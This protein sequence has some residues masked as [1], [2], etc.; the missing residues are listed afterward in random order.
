MPDTLHLLLPDLA[1]TERLAARAAALARPGD[2]LLLE[3][4]LGAGKSA[5]CRAFLRAAAGDPELEVP[6]PSFTLVQG[7]A[8]P[9]GPAFHYDLYRLSG[10]E[11]LE[12]LGW[13]ESRDGIVLVEWPD[14]LGWLA[15]EDAL[16]LSLQ[17]DAGGEARHAVLRGWDSRLPALAG[18]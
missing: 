9:Q 4:P 7:Y 17:P 5:F 13:E 10:P 15:P 3:G 12:E 14:R 2:A 18:L 6:S 1:A 11:E 16:H 8:L